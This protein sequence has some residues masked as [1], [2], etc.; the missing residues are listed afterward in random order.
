MLG[1]NPILVAAALAFLPLAGCAEARGASPS[2][3]S[4]PYASTQAANQALNVA[5]QANM[6]A[7]QARYGLNAGIGGLI[8]TARGVLGTVQTAQRPVPTYCRPSAR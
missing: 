5:Q 7:Q 3:P 1:P 4:N 8:G 6:A 2:C